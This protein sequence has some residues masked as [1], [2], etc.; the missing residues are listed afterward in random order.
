MVELVEASPVIS[1]VDSEEER[2]FLKE[3]EEVEEAIRLREEE[4]RIRIQEL[5]EEEAAFKNYWRAK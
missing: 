1:V 4:E 5:Q 2:E 3:L